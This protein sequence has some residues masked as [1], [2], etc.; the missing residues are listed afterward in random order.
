M[1]KESPEEKARL[2]EE[3]KEK[4]PKPVAVDL[5]GLIFGGGNAGGDKPASTSSNPF[6]TT[7]SSNP[8]APTPSSNPFAPS[9]A[10]PLN[11]FAAAPPPPSVDPPVEDASPE[12]EETRTQTTST[13]ESGPSYPPQY[14][15][16]SY[17]PSSP[18]ISAKSLPPVSNLKITDPLSDDPDLSDDESPVNHRSGK[19]AGGRTKKGSGGGQGRAD[20]SGGKGGPGGSGPGEGYEVQKVKGVDEVFLR[21]QE[22]VSRE[23]LQVIRCGFPPLSLSLIHL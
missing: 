16:T 13:W 23:G 19:G 22:R 12:E 17:E 18:K 11:P 9:T 6:S 10:S 7:Q 14:I 1:W 2:E 20:G 5:G 8:F 21:F 3:K 15:T 4:Q